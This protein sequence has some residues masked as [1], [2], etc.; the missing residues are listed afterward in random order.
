MFKSQ[1]VHVDYINRGLAP[2]RS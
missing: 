1:D 2:R